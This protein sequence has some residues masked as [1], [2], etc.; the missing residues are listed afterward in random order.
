MA[1]CPPE[2]S[3][4]LSGQAYSERTQPSRPSPNTYLSFFQGELEIVFEPGCVGSSLLFPG[5]TEKQPWRR[6]PFAFHASPMT[7]GARL[8]ASVFVGNGRLAG[9]SGPVGPWGLIMRAG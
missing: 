7:V 3:N 4:G 2:V 6:G 5:A 9:Q 1:L 8:S